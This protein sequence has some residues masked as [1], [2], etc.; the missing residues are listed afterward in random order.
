MSCSFTISDDCAEQVEQLRFDLPTTNCRLGT[1]LPVVS[2]ELPIAGS[3][4]PVP[5]IQFAA[6]RHSISKYDFFNI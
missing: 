3:I 2:Y 4:R 1:N 6:L 5:Q